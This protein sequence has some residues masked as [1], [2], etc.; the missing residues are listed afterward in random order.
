LITMSD[1]SRS[2]PAAARRAAARLVGT[3]AVAA[4]L[5]LSACHDAGTTRITV[6]YV[7]KPGTSVAVFEASLQAAQTTRAFTADATADPAPILEM[8]TPGSG[9]VVVTAALADS[10]GTIGGG[11]TAIELRRNATIAVLVQ[12]DSV[13]PST[14]CAECLGAKGF[15]LPASYQRV[16]RD[17]IWMVWTATAGGASITR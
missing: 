3:L 13:N 8:E 10:L 12:I 9:F 16:A 7:A 6:Q 15:V 1:H 4:M 5:P 14:G 2:V 11:T 17:S